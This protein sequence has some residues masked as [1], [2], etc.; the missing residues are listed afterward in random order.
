MNDTNRE[1]WEE[2]AAIREFDGGQLKLEAEKAAT[3]DLMAWRLPPP[4]IPTHASSLY[5]AIYSRAERVR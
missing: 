4:E 1:F 2:R 5:N 3:R